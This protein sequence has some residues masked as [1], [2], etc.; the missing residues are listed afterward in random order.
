MKRQPV[1]SS[2]IASVGYKPDTMMLEIEFRSTGFV[3]RYVDVPEIETDRRV[4]NK[5]DVMAFERIT[6]DP[7]QM[8]GVPC[9]RGLRIPRRDGRGHDCGWND[10]RRNPQGLS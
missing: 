4:N 2:V 10:R 6:V 1:T 5:E 9:I 7:L 3:Y 8:G